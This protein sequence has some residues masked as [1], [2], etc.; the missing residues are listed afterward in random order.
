MSSPTLHTYDQW[1]KLG[2]VIIKGSKAVA[3]DKTNTALFSEYQVKR[4]IMRNCDY[5]DEYDRN[6]SYWDYI[7]DD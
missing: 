5:S 6:D 3:R 7:N 1:H 2:Y 4:K